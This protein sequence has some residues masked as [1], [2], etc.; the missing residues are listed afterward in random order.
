MRAEKSALFLRLRFTVIIDVVIFHQ[1]T[2]GVPVKIVVLRVPQGPQEP[3]QPKTSKDQRGGDQDYQDI[4]G[5]T[6][7]AGRSIIQ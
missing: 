4:L 1:D 6:L 2:P 7:P 3:R 5:A